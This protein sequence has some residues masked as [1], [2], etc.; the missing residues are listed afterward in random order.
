MDKT[1]S[2]SKFHFSRKTFSVLLFY[3]PL[4]CVKHFSLF[5]NA[6][7]ISKYLQELKMYKRERKSAF[8][9]Q[10]QVFALKQLIH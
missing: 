5:N 7:M 1:K 9:C 8:G 4:H 2:N 3:F 6:L 10:V